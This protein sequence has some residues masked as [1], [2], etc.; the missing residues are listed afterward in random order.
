M[1]LLKHDQQNVANVA[2]FAKKRLA[3]KKPA[4]ANA[5]AWDL[6]WTDTNPGLIGLPESMQALSGLIPT[7]FRGKEKNESAH[8]KETLEGETKR[9]TEWQRLPGPNSER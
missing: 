2:R 7:L 4:A 1:S 3:R 8:R 6:P 9:E 5:R